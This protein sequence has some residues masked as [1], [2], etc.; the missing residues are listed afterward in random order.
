MATLA[1]YNHLLYTTTVSYNPCFLR[2]L[3]PANLGVDFD[4]FK[5]HASSK[6]AERFC[7]VYSLNRSASFS[8]AKFGE[9]SCAIVSEAWVAKMNLFWQ[10]YK[11]AAKEDFVFPPDAADRFEPSKEFV[12]LAASATGP[13]ASRIKHIQAIAPRRPR[14]A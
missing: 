13:M 12:E 7:L 11:Q 10:M 1:S 2:P 14:S 9:S 8:I 6:A 4:C 5:A 3:F